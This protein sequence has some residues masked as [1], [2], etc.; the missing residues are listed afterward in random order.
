MQLDLKYAC[1]HTSLD[2]S[3]RDYMCINTHLGLFRY[4]RLPFAI[5]SATDLFQGM[6]EKII[7]ELNFC[8]ILRK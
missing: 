7:S 6:M 8:F 4:T 3:F 2:D 1:L 5:V